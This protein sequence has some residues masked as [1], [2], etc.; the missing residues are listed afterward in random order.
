MKHP[1][2]LFAAVFFCASLYGQPGKVSLSGQLVPGQLASGHLTSGQ[3]VAGSGERI[4]SI[5]LQN[6]DGIKIS[7]PVNARNAFTF[8]GSLP[9]GFYEIDSIGTVYL[10]PG[11]NLVIRPAGPGQQGNYRF[12]GIGAMENNALRLAKLSSLIPPGSM[13]EL[14]PAADSLEPKDFLRKIDSMQY[15]GEMLFNR[16]TDTFFSKYAALDL[17]FY[18]NY[19]CQLYFTENNM[20]NGDQLRTTNDSTR[21][22][23]LVKGAARFREVIMRMYYP[24]WNWNDEDLFRNSSYYRQAF[25][26]FFTFKTFS[27]KYMGPLM[28]MQ[29]GSPNPRDVILIQDQ[30]KLRV[31]RDE[32]SNPY[33][34][35]YFDYSFTRSLLEDAK[36]TA[37]LNK[38]YREYYERSSR[39]DY[40]ATIKEI[41]DNAVSYTDNTPAPLFVYRNNSGNL[42]S[43]NSLL[44]KY[45]YIDVWA[46]WCGPC[47]AELPHLKDVET[48]YR[49]KNIEFV[50]I[51]VDDQ[52]DTKKW[53]TFV[54][55]EDLKG[56]QL[57]TDSAFESAFIRKM[58]IHSIPR[59]ILI[60]PAGKLIS[61][62]AL[63]PSNK[64]LRAE[65]D[66][67]L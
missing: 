55:Q 60:D 17:K 15:R 33:I 5:N 4:R 2:N 39:P 28:K 45:I 21:L 53:R 52:R 65:L 27:M 38:Y 13:D 24:S 7:I 50:S 6:F 51:S 49:D 8:S 3:P 19:L 14:E 20:G 41:Y 29:Q 46:T 35:A 32:I 57:I 36:D 61:A 31:A 26:G 30:I 59:F 67:L 40:R 34:L 48:A 62:D 64:E 23:Q 12:T 47:K 56:I 43:L 16:S 58:G 9:K 44:G 66:K 25:Q 22:S 1:I 54:Q 10:C 42:V 37:V 63:R 18:E 11:Y